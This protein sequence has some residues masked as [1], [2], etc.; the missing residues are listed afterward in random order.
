VI[1]NTTAVAICPLLGAAVT[2]ILKPPLEPEADATELAA[3]VEVVRADVDDVLV[4]LGSVGGEV[5]M[6]E[7]VV[8]LIRPLVPV[9]VWCNCSCLVGVPQEANSTAHPSKPAA[10]DK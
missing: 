7:E 6:A 10:R 1:V 5:M 8:V 9:D 2:W 3:V 4:T